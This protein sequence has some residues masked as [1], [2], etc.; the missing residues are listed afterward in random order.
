MS[1]HTVPGPAHAPASPEP[2]VTRAVNGLTAV[3]GA[4]AGAVL[5]AT[6]GA[7]ALVRRTKP[8][9]PVGQVGTGILDVTDPRPELGVPLL[10]ER[11]SHTCLVRWSRAAGLPEPLPDVEG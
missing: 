1:L 11:R 2:P 8:L 6:F 7:V 10:S 9:H 3:P 5:G 4:V